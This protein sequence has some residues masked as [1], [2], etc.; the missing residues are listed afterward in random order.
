MSAPIEKCHKCVNYWP[1]LKYCTRIKKFTFDKQFN[2]LI[3]HNGRCVN[4][5]SRN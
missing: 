4:V 1:D 2:V 5:S 3:E